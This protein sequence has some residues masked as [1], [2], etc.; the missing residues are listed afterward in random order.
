MIL[1][2][3]FWSFFQITLFTIGG[4]YAALPMIKNVAVDANGW[5]TMAQFADLVVIDEMAPGPIILNS[6]TFVGNQVAGIPGGIAAT[7]GCLAGPAIVVSIIAYFYFKYQGLSVVKSILNYLRPAV[8]AL[9]ASAG[10]SIFVLAFFSDGIVALDN[11][12]LIAVGI[13]IAAFGVL[14]KFKANPS[15][16]IIACGV[17]GGFVYTMV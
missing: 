13:A 4:A 16:I 2:E 1:V 7:I 15:L 14:R 11:I 10:I 5:L 3:L 8:V 12:N 17:I 6:A 9:L